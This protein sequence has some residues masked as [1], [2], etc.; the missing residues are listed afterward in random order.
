MCVEYF[1][2]ILGAAHPKAV[3]N[4]FSQYFSLSQTYLPKKSLK[5]CENNSD[6]RIFRVDSQKLV[7]TYVWLADK[8]S[9]LGVNGP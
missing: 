1:D 9:N 2:Q 5:T 4:T 7:D 6:F 8:P 3:C